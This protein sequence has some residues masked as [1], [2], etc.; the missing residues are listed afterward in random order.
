[1]RLIQ[2]FCCSLLLIASS[3]QGP[4]IPDPE[5]ARKFYQEAKSLDRDDD[6]DRMLELYWQAVEHDP[7]FTEAHREI[8]RLT[9]DKDQLRQEYERR[10]REGTCPLLPDAPSRRDPPCR[11]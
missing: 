10:E 4:P 9:E 6:A 1:M 5:T 7:E 2:I 3:C 8:I 11:P